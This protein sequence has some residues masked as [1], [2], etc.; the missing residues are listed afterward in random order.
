MNNFYKI[1]LLFLMIT[2]LISCGSVPEIHYYVIDYP[3]AEVTDREQPAVNIVLG[4]SKFK[5]DPLYSDGRIVYRESRYEGKYYHY[6][7]WITTPED[8]V[9]DKIVEHLGASNLFAQVIF[10]PKVSKVDYI[11]SGTIKAIEENDTAGQWY[12]SVKIVFELVNRN[13]NELVWQKTIEKQNLISQKS[14][15]E[16]VK[17]I[18]LSLQQCVEALQVDLKDLF[19][20]TE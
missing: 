1:G 14:P 17:G 11:L 8:M 9:T 15:Y 20:K 10:F 19:T 13:S 18:N 12:A 5:S 16:V 4:V 7:R 2:L 3:V 6:H